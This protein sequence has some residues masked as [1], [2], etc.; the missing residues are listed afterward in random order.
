[1]KHICLLLGLFIFS[2]TLMSC[3]SGEPQVG[4]QFEFDGREWELIWQ[5]EFDDPEMDAVKWNIADGPDGLNNDINYNLPKNVYIEDG[6]LVLRQKCESHEGF[7]YTT[8][9][10]NSQN[11]F[12]FLYGRVE[13][14]G[15]VPKGRGLHTAY[16]LLHKGCTGWAGGDNSQCIWP[17]EIDIVEVLGEDTT[18]MHTTYH[19]GTAELKIGTGKEHQLD[20]DLSEDFHTYA[21][22]WAPEEIRWYFDGELVYTADDRFVTDV[23]LPFGITLD[24]VVGGNWPLPPDSLMEFPTYNQIDYV[25]VYKSI[26]N[27]NPP[28]PLP[29]PTKTPDPAVEVETF[30]SA[31]ASSEMPDWP[32]ANAVNRDPATQWTTGENQSPGQWFQ[33]DFG[34]K[35]ILTG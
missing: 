9:K 27:P 20:F 14:R 30:F 4:D 17:P 28:T 26:E 16:W 8:G 2:L 3:Q 33:V 31:S 32:A 12:T 19:A 7:D 21:V 1:M 10:I 18:I 25:R 23:H 35:K 13:V 29:T 6:V 5:D 22:E 34:E 24:T 11:K 15:Q